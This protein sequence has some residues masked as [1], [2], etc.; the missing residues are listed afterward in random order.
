MPLVCPWLCSS[1][2]FYSARR[3][4]YVRSRETHRWIYGDG[5]RDELIDVEDKEN[6]F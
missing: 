2:L 5:W 4:V 3:L 1:E 6:E